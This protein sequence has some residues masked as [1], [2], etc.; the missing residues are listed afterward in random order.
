M[1]KNKCVGPYSSEIELIIVVLT[2]VQGGRDQR[3]FASLSLFLL[4]F[5]SS[6]IFD[7]HPLPLFYLNHLSCST[8]ILASLSMN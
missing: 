4:L 6:V 3:E 2:I 8:V 5:C 7:C 1:C